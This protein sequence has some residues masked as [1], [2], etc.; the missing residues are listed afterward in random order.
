[1]VNQIILQQVS[2]DV[3]L[4][5]KVGHYLIEAGGK[6]LRPLLALL[7]ARA[8]DYRGSD[9]CTLAVVIELIHSATLL[10]DDV[11]DA[12]QL[13]RGRPTAN[14]KWGNSPSVL[15]G[16]FLFSRAFQMIV[17]IGDMQIMAILSRAINVIAEGEVQQLINIGDSKLSEDKYCEV[18]YKKTAIL[19]ESA[20]EAAAIMSQN[21]GYC[22]EPLS[23]PLKSYGYHLGMAF[24]L[25]DDL[26]DYTSESENLG[27]NVGDDLS[28]GKV[29]LPLIIAIKNSSQKDK[30]TIVDAV[31]KGSGEHNRALLQEIAAII[32][33][34]GALEY[35]QQRAAS[36][37][38]QA[39]RA[40]TGLSDS[41]YKQALMGLASFAI[42]RNH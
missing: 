3:G 28:E 5:E 6:R 8:T 41:K 33:K 17:A 11:V 22:R 19:F 27:K 29:T 32:Q 1:M 42:D 21:Q 7:A 14:A 15:V 40:L 12:S 16:D 9:Q 18:I 25:T 20:C 34:T 39:K 13:R 26:L 35:T 36:H 23:Q 31:E 4:V 24:Q 37:V 10:H 38:E 2:S 30:K